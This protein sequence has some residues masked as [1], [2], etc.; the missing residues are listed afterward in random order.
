MIDDFKL[1]I[2][3]CHFFNDANALMSLTINFL[4]SSTSLRPEN[5]PD[6][7][8]SVQTTISKFQN[9]K[10]FKVFSIQIFFIYITVIIKNTFQAVFN[11]LK[12]IFH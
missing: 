10:I 6:E 12:D 11:T 1:F 7:P 3:L 5:H 4:P 2:M 8:K 9:F